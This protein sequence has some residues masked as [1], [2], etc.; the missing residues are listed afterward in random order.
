MSQQQAAAIIFGLAVGEALSPESDPKTAFPFSYGKNTQA[1][2][3][4][5]ETVLSAEN[6]P[7]PQ[8]EASLLNTALA[9]L[10]AGHTML[11]GCLYQ[12]DDTRLAQTA[13]AGSHPAGIAANTAAA[14]LVKL[15]LDGVPLNDYLRRVMLFTDGI[16]DD[17]DA[18]I[19]RIGHVLGW[20]NVAAACQHIA[21][22]KQPHEI[23]A[24][25]L[26]FVLRYPD[27]FVACVR[28]AANTGSASACLA[29]GL[30]G[31]RLGLNAIPQAWRSGCENA[32][33]LIDL[34]HRLS[35]AKGQ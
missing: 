18:A 2:L 31:A 7:H 35:Q 11:I 29:G 9:V 32:A 16:S 10:P 20:T 8:P 25:A 28:G 27:D 22:D 15:A 34:S 26:Y 33:Y 12:H 3:A 4:A 1:A 14:Y 5:A 17:F 23:V 21:H 6:N 19:L 24:L 30:M 13:R